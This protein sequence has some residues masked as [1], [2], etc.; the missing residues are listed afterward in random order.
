MF[1]DLANPTP[2]PDVRSSK[3]YNCLDGPSQTLWLPTF[4]SCHK[5]D[6]TIRSNFVADGPHGSQLSSF[7]VLTGRFLF[8]T[9]T[10]GDGVASVYYGPSS[11]NTLCFSRLTGL[12]SFPVVNPTRIRHDDSFELHRRQSPWI[13]TFVFQSPHSG[14]PVHYGDRWGWHSVH[15]YS[16]LKD[17]TIFLTQLS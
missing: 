4:V 17:P 16:P 2:R 8:I 12:P 13:P 11:L 15:S 7:K 5:F 3:R 14:I 6:T 10:G 1:L 9:G